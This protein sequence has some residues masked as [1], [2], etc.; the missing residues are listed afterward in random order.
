M[1]LKEAEGSSF[2][3]SK[4]GEFSAELRK[5]GRDIRQQGLQSHGIQAAARHIR[6]CSKRS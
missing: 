2:G 4:E 1:V 6:F 5:P 3:V